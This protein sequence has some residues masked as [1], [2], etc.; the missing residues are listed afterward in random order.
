LIACHRLLDVGC[1][2]LM[3]WAALIGTGLG[4]VH[5]YALH[6]L[7]ERL[8]DIPLLVDAGLGLLSHAAMVMEWGFDGVL[9]NTAVS[10]SGDPVMM[11][12]EFALAVNTGRLAYEVE[13]V[14]PHHNAQASMPQ[15]GQSF[16]YYPD[17]E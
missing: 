6:V 1:R 8:P 5:E 15:V 11:A 16:W 4:S 10:R 13:P 12:E 2:A 9:L 17:Y 7:R 14:V 3:P